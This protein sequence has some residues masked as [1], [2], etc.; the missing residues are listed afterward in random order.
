M[1][2]RS[3][4]IVMLTT[5]GALAHA[6]DTGEPAKAG[7]SILFDTGLSKIRPDQAV[8]LDQ[9]ARTFRAGNPIVMI[10]AGS[11]DTVGDAREN[12]DLSIRRAR[13][14]ADGLV[15]RGI[16]VDRLQILGRG[17]SEL[18]VPTS[19]GVSNEANRSVSI[20]WR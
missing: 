2:R 9:A 3:F 4:L 7:L 5:F 19:E 11:A 1:F 14:V 20:T 13:V 16:P 10:V 8:K 18:P 15:A 6:Q 17:V 12:L